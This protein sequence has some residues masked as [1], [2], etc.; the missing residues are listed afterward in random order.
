MLREYLL[1]SEGAHGGQKRSLGP[2]NLGLQ[3]V[4]STDV[5]T[6]NRTQVLQ[7]HFKH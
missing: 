3:A 5:G 6:E 1:V 7:V 4:V 2:L